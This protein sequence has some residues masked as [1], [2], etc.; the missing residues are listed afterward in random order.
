MRQKVLNDQETE[1]KH[2]SYLSF[3]LEEEHFCIPVMKVLEILEV[4]RITKVPHSP[5]YMK[6]V[7]NLRGAV[8][9]VIDTRVKFGMSP[10]DFTINTSILVLDIQDKEESLTAGIL[11]DAV[12]EV[13]ELADS[14][15]QPSPSIGA[16]YKSDF[17]Q[18]MIH[19]Q[20]EFM[21]LLDID[22]IFSLIELQDILV[23][24]ED[25]EKITSTTKSS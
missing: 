13:C 7:I 11:V 19:Y 17:I 1:E 22:K 4:P 12:L 20:E 9:P 23:R 21:M 2:Q 5:E 14:K 15:I 10:T 18:G 25:S 6:G 8:L 24:S 16:K 3:K